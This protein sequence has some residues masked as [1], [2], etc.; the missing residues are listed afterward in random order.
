MVGNIQRLL[1]GNTV[2]KCWILFLEGRVLFVLVL[3]VKEWFLGIM[4]LKIKKEKRG[5]AVK[6]ASFYRYFNRHF[7]S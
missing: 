3:L 2:T 5:E 6:L 7:P 1:P 4:S